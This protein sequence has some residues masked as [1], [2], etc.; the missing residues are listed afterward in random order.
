MSAIACFEILNLRE[1]ARSPREDPGPATQTIK[2]ERSES[3]PAIP[4]HDTEAGPD[5]ERP[6]KANAGGDWMSAIA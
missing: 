2:N 1:I 3:F 5:P 4:A 6:K